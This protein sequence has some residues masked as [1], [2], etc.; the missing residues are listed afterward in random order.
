MKLKDGE[1]VVSMA[2]LE[3]GERDTEVR[4]AYLRAAEWKNNEN[5]A[6]LDQAKVDEMAEAEEF[7]LTLT[8]NGYGKISSAYEYRTTGRG[9]QGL[10]NIGE[11]TSNPDRNGPV[12]ASF[13][14]RHGMQLMLVTDRAKLIRLPL[15]FRHLVENGFETHE[16]YSIS[17]RGSSGVRIFNVSK[18]EQIVGAARID[19]TE[20]PE[21]LAEEAVA[22][23]IAER[24]GLDKTEPYTTP[25]SDKNID[26]E[27]G[28]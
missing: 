6:T 26:G 5:S 28:G 11:P 1:K 14:V 23:E 25:H 12:V 4:D 7:I 16:G 22:D 10:T 19:E 17:G 27:A 9:G 13:P 24:G 3:T 18:G 20:E 21:N 15:Q 8:A 2:V